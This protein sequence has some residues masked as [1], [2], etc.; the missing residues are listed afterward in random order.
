MSSPIGTC[1]AADATYGCLPPQTIAFHKDRSGWIP[2]GR[3]FVMRPGES[4]TITIAE[5]GGRDDSGYLVAT[6]PLDGTATRFYT[7]E[8]RRLDGYDVNVP[9]DAVLI[10]R[11]DTSRLRQDD[12]DTPAAVVVDADDDGNPNDHGAM[13]LAGEQFEDADNGITVAVPATDGTTATIAID[14]TRQTVPPAIVTQPVDQSIAS[15]GSA[16]FTATA[17]GH[18][19]PT[20]HWQRSADGGTSFV[21]LAEG[22]NYR[23]VDTSTLSITAVTGSLSGQ[24]FRLV[25]TS[26]AGIATSAAATLTIF[27]TELKPPTGLSAVAIAGNEVTLAWA[28]PI[29][30]ITP[31]GYVVEGG[32]GPGGVVGGFLTAGPTTTV[33][34]AAP[35]GAYFVRV[36]SLAGDARSPASNEIRIFVN[37]PPPPDA[38]IALL[39]LADES[40]VTLAWRNSSLGGR[41]PASSSTSPAV[42]PRRSPCRYWTAC[43]LAAF[44]PASTT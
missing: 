32:V 6:I 17:S 5:L 31:T 20:L 36:H 30:S 44:Q 10:H 4:E 39:G 15:G 21:D 29:D 25:A 13:W 42:P 16:S 8:V 19:T 7:V 28:A 3:A 18:P 43:R 26:P 22:P 11:V 40:S 35:T 1:A 14:T 23:G 41:H 12:L 27:H 9:A 37:V 34:F 33:T 24:Q 2:P 38:P